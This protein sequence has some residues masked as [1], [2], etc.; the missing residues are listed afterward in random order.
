MPVPH[1]LLADLK[2]PSETYEA[3]RKDD[4][5]LSDLH[6]EY[7]AKDKEVLVAEK[8]GTSDDTVNRFRKERALIKEKIV[9]KIEQ[10]NKD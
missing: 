5:Q 10:H 7:L 1:D 3:L 6:K 9:R 2:L 8:N 4:Q